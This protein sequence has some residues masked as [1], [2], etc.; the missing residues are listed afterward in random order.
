MNEAD[1]KRTVEDYLTYKQN[2]GALYFD[3]LNSGEAI[4]LKGD[5][6]YKIN[7][8]RE[9]TADFMV[10]MWTFPLGAPNKGW[11]RV[12]FLEL[13]SK[14]GKQSEDQRTFQD[15]VEKQGASYFIIRNLE[16][17]EVLLSR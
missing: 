6:H 2:Q 16:E 8:C 1:L 13:K 7:L 10:L 15:A 11:T 17:L 9:G 14:T 4:V 5:K 12:I 3:R